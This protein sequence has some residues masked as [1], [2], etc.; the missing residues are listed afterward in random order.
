MLTLDKIKL[1]APIDGVVIVDQSQFSSVQEQGRVKSQRISLTE[2]CLLKLEL[3]YDVGEAVIEFT[4]KILG[5]DYPQLISEETILKCFSNIE[6]M[7]FCRFDSAVMLEVAEIVKCD[8]TKDIRVNDV[9]RMTKWIKPN[10]SNNQTYICRA[11]RNGNLIIEKNNTTPKRN[12][13]L[14]IYDKGQEMRLSGNREY[15]A[16]YE[17]EG[18]FDGVCRFELNLCTKQQIKDSLGVTRAT[19]SEVLHSEQNPLV[20]FLT[21]AITE[22]S[23]DCGTK[24]RQGW[25]TFLNG[26]LLQYCNNDLERVEALLRQYYDPRKDK[27]RKK[28]EPFRALYTQSTQLVEAT[29]WTKEKLLSMLR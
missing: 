17:M 26:L 23:P 14:T 15:V 5:R 13:R 8:V 4:G 3:N 18:R 25:N 2:P 10:I 29:G 27:I 22:V 9:A 12:K 16:Q 24:G 1:V 19:L 6:E 7:G 28:M 11:L 21:S 20:S